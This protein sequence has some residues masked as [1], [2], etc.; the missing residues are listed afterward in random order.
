MTAYF[1]GHA[2]LQPQNHKTTTFSKLF[3]NFHLFSKKIEAKLYLYLIITTTHRMPKGQMKKCFN[4][5]ENEMVHFRV[6]EKCARQFQVTNK[7]LC[8]KLL[9]KHMEKEHGIKDFVPLDVLCFNPFDRSDIN[10]I[11]NNPSKEEINKL[12]LGIQGTFKKK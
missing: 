7:R 3:L 8:K 2:H 10:D 11:S 12:C 4:M 1:R 6:C 9:I 5:A